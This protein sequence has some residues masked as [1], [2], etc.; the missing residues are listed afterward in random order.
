MNG[1]YFHM[2]RLIEIAT[3][4][5]VS[6]V[7]A[8]ALH[9]W[10]ASRDEQQR[11]AQTLASQKK[12]IDSAATRESSREADL[13]SA[14]AQIDNLR[15]S[16]QSPKQII[17]DLPTYLPLPQPISFATHNPSGYQAP[18]KPSSSDQENV[19]S[20]KQGNPAFEKSS[21]N[22]AAQIPAPDLKP[23]FDYVQDCRACQ[24]QLVAAKQNALDEAA[25]ITALTRERD[26]AVTAA[27]GGSF[28]RRLRR[29]ALWFAIGAAVGYGAAKR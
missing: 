2:R 11:L 9:A 21:D 5:I 12:I 20:V 26:A 10:L 6:L 1:W 27:K 29:N 4:L 28:L 18:S 22:A 15:R 23:L 3:L 17:Q 7:A 16:V 8:L 24:A 19:S 14:L 25:Q 13:N